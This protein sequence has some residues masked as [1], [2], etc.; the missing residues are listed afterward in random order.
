MNTRLVEV[1]WTV[2]G[3]RIVEKRATDKDLVPIIKSFD[4]REYRVSDVKVQVVQ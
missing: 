1:S 2:N 3:K 4:C